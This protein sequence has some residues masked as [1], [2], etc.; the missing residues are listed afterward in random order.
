A[1]GQLLTS[2][3]TTYEYDD[4]GNL[5][6]KSSSKGTWKYDWNANGMLKS[7]YRPDRSIVEMEYDA[8]GRRTTKISK[9]HP[10]KKTENTPDLITRFVWNGNV[11][12][13]EWQYNLKNKP[14]SIVDAS[15]SLS[16]DQKEPIENLITWVFDQGSFKP[17][18]KITENDTYSI[19]TDHLG[20]P[21]EM[22]NSNGEKTW[23]AEY[24]IYGKIRNLVTGSLQD[25]PFRFQGQYEDLEIDLFYN[26]FRYYNPEEGVYISQD[27]IR[28]SGNNPTMYAY[29][30]DSNSWVD[31]FGLRRLAKWEIEALDN[32]LKNNGHANSLKGVY[33]FTDADGLNYTGS[34]G[35][36]GGTSP[37]RVRLMTHM[38]KDYLKA[39]DMNS[40]S[41]QEM[42]NASDQQVWDREAETI[43]ENGGI[44]N[45]NVANS[46]RPPNTGNTAKKPC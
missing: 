36:R 26:R 34:A 3:N 32:W 21:V 43:R 7:I 28:L 30:H 27:P 10:S 4:E 35:T 11:L 5:I 12:L 40:L 45:E 37:L 39:N 19:I 9:Q 6:K 42:N 20:T 1:N 15:G 38:R 33:N 46:K 8:L 31:P 13:H 16:N 29:T 41:I 24:D 22:Y 17:A 44:G 18:A 23:H 14:K 25:C 2:G